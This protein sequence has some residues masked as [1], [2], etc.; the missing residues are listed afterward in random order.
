[1]IDWTRVND[2]RDEVGAEDLV[3][4]AD[5][6]LAEMAQVLDP[7]RDGAD[8]QDP[9]DLLHFLKGAA[10]NLGFADLADICA[11][12]EMAQVPPDM[13]AIIAVFDASKTEFLGGLSIP[14]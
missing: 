5:I 1:M 4:I 8:A 10:L 11:Q 7:L 14:A 12:S 3:E 2:L 9:A 13:G 6:F